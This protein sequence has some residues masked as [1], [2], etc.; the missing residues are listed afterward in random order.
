MGKGGGSLPMNVR[1]FTFVIKQLIRSH[2]GNHCLNQIC[3]T[4]G[5]QVFK[6]GTKMQLAT[7][8]HMLE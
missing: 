8:V 5:D 4:C 6:Q 1:K 7:V 3:N 2:L